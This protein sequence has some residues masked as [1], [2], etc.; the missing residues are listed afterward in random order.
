MRA[1][2]P[3]ISEQQGVSILLLDRRFFMWGLACLA[4]GFAIYATAR[5]ATALAFLPHA[6]HPEA[7]PHWLKAALGPAPTL[8]HVMAFSL[9]SAAV[10][11]RTAR[12]C[13]RVCAAWAAIEVAFEYLQY[14]AVRSW[15]SQ[16]CAVALR[17]PLLGNYIYH[18]SF[19]LDD[20]IA[21]VVGAACAAALMTA[22]RA[23][24]PRTPA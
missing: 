7:L 22:A 16:H 17:L 4:A 21:A 14:P 5:P 19:D 11:A 18:G 15:L 24:A 6:S 1:R 2:T 3:A 8:V 23:R 10:I 9:L 12:D 13:W 20:L